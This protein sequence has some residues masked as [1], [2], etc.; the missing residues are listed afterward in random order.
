MPPVKNSRQSSIG[1]NSP[2]SDEVEEG[3]PIMRC[4]EVIREL[5]APTDMRDAAALA[6][7]L[8]RCPSC[9]AFSD[10]AVWLDR[11][12][13]ATRPAE[14]APEVWD[15]LW[16]Q[17]ACTLARST[18]QEIASAVS[19]AFRNG[20]TSRAVLKF[21]V[22]RPEVDLPA[23]FRSRLWAAVGIAGLS[24][25]AAVLLVAGLTWWFFVP[26]KQ[27]LAAL[28]PATSNLTNPSSAA[29]PLPSVDIEE[30]H[31]VVILA[32]PKNPSVVDRTPKGMTVA[33]DHPY[34]DWYGDEGYFDWP[35]VFNEVES[36]A[37]PR[38]AMEN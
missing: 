9:A 33:V 2:V 1:T 10:R 22:K 13:E 11:L 6:D 15:S 7:H 12:W 19:P 4:E 21:E 24:Q 37:K 31:L 28:S 18:N 5:A 3:V 36:F 26:P 32:D 38:V 25:V 20:S 30:G 23:S 34:L 16:S 27:Q 8:S 35:R 29:A 14:P 17:V